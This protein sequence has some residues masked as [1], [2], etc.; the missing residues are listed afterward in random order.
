[1]ITPLPAF[2][3]RT[4]N[5]IPVPL[6][7]ACVQRSVR[8]H[9]FGAMGQM[10]GVITFFIITVLCSIVATSAHGTECGCKQKQVIKFYVH[11][12]L[13]QKEGNTAYIIAG[14]GGN[15][16]HLQQGSLVAIN[17][18]ITE[19]PDPHS[20]KLGNAQGVYLL[21]V[22]FPELPHIYQQ[23]TS[24]FTDK[25]NGSTI[26]YQGDDGNLLPVREI[27]VVGGTGEFRSA[28]GYCFIRTVKQTDNFSYILEFETHLFVPTASYTGDE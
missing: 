24:V 11:D 19:G 3:F 8:D 27:A 26:A 21:S 15:I 10:K 14:P 7:G 23:F 9:C 2:V 13:L 25:W 1:M 28:S 16:T 20:R 4:S 17:D 22:T 6:F 12:N 5:P 18:L